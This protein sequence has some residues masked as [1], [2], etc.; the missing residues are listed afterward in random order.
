MYKLKLKRFFSILL[1]VSII[2]TMFTGLLPVQAGAETVTYDGETATSDV[3][4]NTEQ[5]TSDDVL[6]VNIGDE[7]YNIEVGGIFTVKK[8]VILPDKYSVFGGKYA[9]YF[10]PEYLTVICTDDSEYASTDLGITPIAGLMT[11]GKGVSA[12]YA[13]TGY[14]KRNW[15]NSDKDNFA[16]FTF[17]V[18]AAGE[19]TVREL[20]EIG[21]FF[22]DESTKVINPFND[23]IYTTEVKTLS[24]ISVC[25]QPTKTTYNIGEDLNTDGLELELTYND[26]S[27]G[28][29]TSGFATSGFDSSTAG[30]QTVTVTYGGRTATFNV[31][32]IK[33][34][35]SISV[36][37]QPTKTTYDIGE[38]LNTEGLELE[39][40]YN[41]NSTERVTDGFTVSELDSA[42]AGT[43][44]VTVTYGGKT[45]TFGVTV[46]ERV[47]TLVG[48]SVYTQPTKTTYDI[49]E[50]LE[51]AGLKLE[52]TYSDNS[53]GY[54]TTD[55]T[56][57]GFDSSTAGTKTVTVTY[58]GKTATFDVT[59]KAK[60]VI[61]SDTL[62]V[63]IGEEYYDIKV[64]NIFTV[65][66]SVILPE[67]Y[68]VQG[69]KYALYYDSEYL[70]A[71]YTNE[72]DE[73]Y[74]STDLSISPVCGLMAGNQ[75][76]SVA[77]A[78]S[79][80][81]RKNWLNANKDNFATFTFEA[82]ASGEITIREVFEIGV[83]SSDKTKESIEQFDDGT[84]TTVIRTLSAISICTEPTTTTYDIGESLN[85]E[86]LELELTYS[87]NSTERVTSGFTT[88]GFDSTATG[89]KTVTVTYGGYTATFNVTVIK[90][91]S[92]ISVNTKPTKTT[93][94]I[95]E[96]LDTEGLEVEL[97]YS[98]NSTERVTDGF[99]TSGFDSTAT[100]TKTITV[101]YE[102]KTATF[103]V[104][105]IK[106]L[107]SI[108]V[109][110]KPTKTTY[111][112]GEELNT[113]GL[114]LELTYSDNSTER[115]TD[116][117]TTS[118]F[119]S[120]ATGTKTVTVTYEGKTATFDI[121][122]I[123]TLS[124]ISICTQ[125]D[126]TT[127]EV[128]EELNTEGLELE[129]TYSDNS[130]ERVT[131]GFTTSGFDS[132]TTGTKTV[133]VTYEG[134]TATFDVTIIITIG[135][136]NGDGK[137]NST[138]ATIILQYYAGIVDLPDDLAANADVNNDGNIDSS[139]AT[140]V[141]QYYANIISFT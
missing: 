46:N 73:E 6:K 91:I 10:D 39:L 98:D 132:T 138:D 111:D 85:T 101:T 81:L 28:R 7:S 125:P 23:G 61:P 77:Y 56:T 108:S 96:E 102:G 141:L 122:V 66:K 107:S 109:N 136:T 5:A 76:I 29:V 92:S 94:D 63:H 113:E 11:G 25:T 140:L 69:G 53:K 1:S 41:D 79:K 44:T 34:L 124:S 99:T 84:Y 43:K 114:E 12:A 88:S 110:T 14:S 137:V 120:T 134:K 33:T 13:T 47:A 78:T 17:E 119:D 121:T 68:S 129:L 64:G 52:L 74:V 83:F 32:V 95:G 15:L 70:A 82:K 35:S 24:S 75:G 97:T 26:N 8:S 62:R 20:F 117:F 37:T 59:I 40:K 67:G 22:A 139:D 21:V 54:V 131:D 72:A 9:L 16:T 135:D 58:E 90:T 126:K 128:G 103:D 38:S 112:I 87:D 30:T 45:A 27:T 115:V 18:K 42:T 106:T 31:T 51:T 50:D 60:P 89:T 123:K 19:I 36:C 57:S 65:K 2:L 71:V 105:V 130:T 3:T 48:I 80:Y 118:G 116:G 104:T 93:Y 55:F 100:G 133:T 49:G 86:G 127:Y 4:V